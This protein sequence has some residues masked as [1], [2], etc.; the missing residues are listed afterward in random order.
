MGI[1]TIWE[2]YMAYYVFKSWLGVWYDTKCWLGIWYDVKCWYGVWYDIKLIGCLIWRKVL[3]R[4]LIWHKVLIRSLIWHKVLIGNLIWRKVLNHCWYLVWSDINLIG[5]EQLAAE[6]E[7]E[8]RSS[9]WLQARLSSQWKQ[10]T[11][12]SQSHSSQ[13]AAAVLAGVCVGQTPVTLPLPGSHSNHSSCSFAGV[14]LTVCLSCDIKAP[15]P[16]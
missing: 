12:T 7:C 13:A 2:F 6:A 8:P 16:V 4:S 9:G 15:H 10:L 14:I 1:A 3:I 5:C 11:R